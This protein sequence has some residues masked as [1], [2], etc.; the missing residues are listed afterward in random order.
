MIGLCVRL[1]EQK[2]ITY[3]LKAMPEVIAK[4]P[5]ITLIIAGKGVLREKLEKEAKKLGVEDNVYFIGPRMDIA[6]LLNIFDL[7]VLPSIWEGLPMVVIEAMAAKCPIL[8]TNVGGNG[9]AIVN[10]ESGILIEPKNARALT[11]AIIDVL[12]DEALRSKLKN[13]GKLTTDY[14]L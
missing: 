1:S 14:G 8:A 5:D 6:E 2:G 4:Y 3:L 13:N 7:Y 10:G 9:Q 12:S 11:D